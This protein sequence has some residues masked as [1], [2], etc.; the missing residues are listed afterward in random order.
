MT[1]GARVV[2]G[3]SQLYRS[4]QSAGMWDGTNPSRITQKA[5]SKD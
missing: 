2:M 4:G 1:L 5:Q 3:R